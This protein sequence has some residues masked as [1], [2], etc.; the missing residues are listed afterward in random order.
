M[1]FASPFESI[2]AVTKTRIGS[3]IKGGLHSHERHVPRK[4]SLA[5]K[6]VGESRPGNLKHGSGRRY[7]EACRLDNLSPNE[8]SRMG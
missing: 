8:I 6:E 2:P 4:V 7:R 1:V 3:G 5:V